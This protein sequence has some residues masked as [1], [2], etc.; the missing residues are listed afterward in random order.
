MADLFAGGPSG[1]GQAAPTSNFDSFRKEQ[2]IFDIDAEI[3]DGVLYLGVPEQYLDGPEIAGGLI[4]HRDLGPAHRM[5]SI[6]RASQPD[7]SNPF[8]DQSSILPGA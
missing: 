7:R 5:R 4:N 2:R 6:F 3:P 1:Y 8:I